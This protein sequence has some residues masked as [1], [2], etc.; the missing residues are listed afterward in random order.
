MEVAV[1]DKDFERRAGAMD[2]YSAYVLDSWT[3]AGKGAIDIDNTVYSGVH[4]EI[5]MLV[6]GT[7]YVL[8]CN[9]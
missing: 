3:W 2:I 7:W 5:L 4:L 6:P 9:T 8:S 1:S